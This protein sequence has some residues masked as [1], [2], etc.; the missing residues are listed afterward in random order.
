MQREEIKL[1]SYFKNPDKNEATLFV[2]WRVSALGKLE[3]IRT[4]LSGGT[5]KE[6]N[7]LKNL[8]DE[9]RFILK[10]SVEGGS[11]RGTI[12][13]I[14]GKNPTS[15]STDFFLPEVDTTPPPPKFYGWK[16]VKSGPTSLFFRCYVFDDQ[17][18]RKTVRESSFD[19]LRFTEVGGEGYFATGSCIRRFGRGYKEIDGQMNRLPLDKWGY[20]PGDSKGESFICQVNGQDVVGAGAESCYTENKPC[21]L[22]A[23]S[24][25]N[26]CAGKWGYTKIL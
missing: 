20:R 18:V 19:A 6:L 23:E 25:K 11:V 4:I 12:K 7:E 5:S 21:N 13:G 15:F 24:I 8:Q 14:A 10:R 17:G 9:D 3:D 22:G 1:Y 26:Y 16:G 2:R